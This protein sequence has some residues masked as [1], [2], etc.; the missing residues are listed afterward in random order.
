MKIYDSVVKVKTYFYYNPDMQHLSSLGELVL[1]ISC[2]GFGAVSFIM[3]MMWGAH[4]DQFDPFWAFVWLIPLLTGL[5]AYPIKLI[6]YLIYH[7]TSFVTRS[8]YCVEDFLTSILANGCE[9]IIDHKVLFVGNALIGI[10]LCAVAILIKLVFFTSG[11]LSLISLILL[12]TI[13]VIMGMMYL[14]RWVF[15]LQRTFRK[16][17]NDPNA[18]QRNNQS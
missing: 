17:L 15:D 10:Y 13:V 9:A 5:L 8:E 12:I 14:S 18:H 2:V 3:A 1:Y 11:W 7:I 4:K 16:H 6:D